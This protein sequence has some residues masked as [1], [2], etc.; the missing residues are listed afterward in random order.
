GLSR[1]VQFRAP[2]GSVLGELALQGAGADHH[3]AGACVQ[4][5]APLLD[6]LRQREAETLAVQTASRLRSAAAAAGADVVWMESLLDGEFS[7]IRQRRADAGLGWLTPAG[8]D[9]AGSARRHE[10]GRIR[11]RTVDPRRGGALNPAGWRTRCP[12][13]PA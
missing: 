10:P 1:G 13:A 11:A 3:H 5:R 12:P 8:D 4:R 2:V 6:H 7:L 9:G